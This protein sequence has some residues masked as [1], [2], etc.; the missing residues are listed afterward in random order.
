[1]S[2]NLANIKWGCVQPL[3][4]GMYLG[5]EKAIGHPAEWIISYENLLGYI[6]DKQ[7]NIIDAPNEQNTFEYL[8]NHGRR[9]DWFFLQRE[10]FQYDNDVHPEYKFNGEG[11]KQ[12]DLTDMDL[13][14]A[15]PV[16]AGLSMASTASQSRKDTCN[17]QMI[18]MTKYVLNGIKPKVYIFENAPTLLSGRGDEVRDQL[19]TIAMEAGYSTVYYKTDTKLHHN[20]QKRPRTFILF[21]KN[22]DGKSFIPELHYE[23]DQMT[24]RDFFAELNQITFANDPM[25][26]TI[27]GE[28]TCEIPLAYVQYR[29]GDN[30]REKVHGDLFDWVTRKEEETNTFMEWLKANYDEK[31]VAWFTKYVNHI[32]D[33]RSNNLGYWSVTAKYFNNDTL[34]ACMYKNMPITVHHEENR[35]YTMREWLWTMGHPDDYNMIGEA[36]NFFR[37]IGQNVPVNTAKW[38]V[39]E[40]ARIVANW[41]NE[42]SISES[43]VVYY[44]NTRQKH[45]ETLATAGK[46]LEVKED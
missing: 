20:C 40:A 25:N 29:L 36:V 31:A 2:K 19:E 11:N 23:K 37:R 15:V 38:I 43:R 34:P 21:F 28:Y 41:D 10:N 42:Q 45:A 39:S 14:V 33:K 3:T 35:L 32:L 1:M 46:V 5:A 27:G 12:P 30:W 13:V 16:C 44:D 24:V 9:P 6:K 17:C 18:W 8:E 26:V 7:G 4:G 22:K